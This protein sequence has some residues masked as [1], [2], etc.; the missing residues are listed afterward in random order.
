[1]KIEADAK[2]VAIYINSTDQWHG[3]PLYSAIVELC[4]ERG[5]AGATVIR[6]AEGYG[7][8]GH[9]HTARLLELSEHLAVKIEIVDFAGRIEELIPLLEPMIRE[10]LV[11]I[12]DVH[13]QRHLPDPKG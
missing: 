9:I 2:L 11:T 4:K 3:R 13:I 10:G 1:M 8:S 5:I 7:R 6:A 12:A